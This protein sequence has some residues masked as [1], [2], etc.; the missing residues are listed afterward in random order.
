MTSKHARR[1][2]AIRPTAPNTEIEARLAANRR[3]LPAPARD[4]ARTSVAASA[5]MRTIHVYSRYSSA[6]QDPASIER[7]HATV[8]RYLK[9]LGGRVRVVHMDEIGESAATTLRP[10]LQRLLAMAE[11]GE[12]TDVAF[13]DFDRVSR[14]I[15]GAM[16]V[17]QTLQAHGVRLHS[18]SEER[19]L[20]K[21]ELAMHATRAER[22]RLRRRNLSISGI[23]ALIRAGGVPN[24]G[25]YG[26]RKGSV[27]GFPEIDESA[28]TVIR[29]IAALAVAGIP[30]HAIAAILTQEGYLSP[31]GQTAWGRTTIVKVVSNPLLVGK[32]IYRATGKAKDEA[33]GEMRRWRN[34]EGVQEGHNERYRILPDQVFLAVQEA[35]DARRHSTGARGPAGIHYPPLIG[36]VHCDCGSPK[37][38]HRSASLHKGTRKLRYM[39]QHRSCQAPVR[40]FRAEAIESAVVRLVGERLERDYGSQFADECVRRR[41]EA[42]AVRVAK[43]ADCEAALVDRRRM[44]DRALEKELREG[45]S[46]RLA[47]YQATLDREIRELSARR[48]HLV[49]PIPEVDPTRLTLHDE[50]KAIADRIP[51]RVSSDADATFAAAMRAIVPRVRLVRTGMPINKVRVQV[52]LDL[53]SAFLPVGG[54][55]VL[56]GPLET[57]E[58]EVPTSSGFASVVTAAVAERAAA[59][60]MHALD[61]RRWALVEGLLPDVAA[62]DPS[63]VTLRNVA[64]AAVFCMKMEIPISRPPI[65]FGPTSVVY[66]LLQRLAYHGGIE[67]LVRVLSEDDPAWAADLMPERLSRLKRTR[68]KRQPAARRAAEAAVAGTYDLTDAQWQTSLPLIHP[69]VAGLDPENADDPRRVVDAALCILRT[70]ASWSQIPHA[71]GE[72][73]R[74][75]RAVIR[76]RYTGSWARLVEAW[77]ISHPEL[78]DG[79]PPERLNP[80]IRGLSAEW[81][82]SARVAP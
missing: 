46:D 66:R 32:I 77:R 67:T 49:D 16:R 71:F 57:I 60:G 80:R 42:E 62:G 81:R 9:K 23:D 33:T 43:L 1:P 65:S 75:H 74:I 61:D 18:A 17:C 54:R 44:A 64:S 52:S 30:A 56:G 40:T 55:A 51:L 59:A 53:A 58:L 21:E 12:V 68:D 14:E 29:K 25:A 20:T 11:A 27:P 37:P 31:T 34:V 26:Y 69:A 36:E 38:I 4:A 41:A 2:V 35:I 22:D 48:E 73:Q 6:A 24:P 76:L 28:A 45:H 10:Q 5:L 79:L 19:V 47:E 7:Q 13:E 72:R 3:A 70:G 8:A 15:Y 63:G 82:A 50:I 39:C 78:V